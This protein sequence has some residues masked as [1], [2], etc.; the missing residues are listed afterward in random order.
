MVLLRISPPIMV[1]FEKTT[2]KVLFVNGIVVECGF[3]GIEQVNSF[4]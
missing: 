1:H 2:D 4:A 3:A